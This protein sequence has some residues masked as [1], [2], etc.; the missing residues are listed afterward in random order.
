MAFLPQRV[1]F[2]KVA[3]RISLTAPSS[4]CPQEKTMAKGQKRSNR[5]LKKPKAAKSPKETMPAGGASSKASLERI[6]PSK[7]KR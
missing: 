1:E 3:E 5:E 6:A 2:A 7:K 4:R